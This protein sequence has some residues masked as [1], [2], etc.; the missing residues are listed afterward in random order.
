[1]AH[2]VG[3]PVIPLSIVNASE[4]NPTTWMFPRMPSHGKAKVIVHDP[5]ESEGITEDE[6][7]EKVREAILSGLPKE[8]HP[9]E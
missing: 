9:L 8:Q 7:A 3:A 4:V 2:K 1:M 5:I 6:L